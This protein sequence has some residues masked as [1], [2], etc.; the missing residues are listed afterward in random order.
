MVTISNLNNR[1]EIRLTWLDSIRFISQS[2]FV[3]NTWKNKMRRELK[4]D[5]FNLAL[6]LLNLY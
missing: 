1:L 5:S 6:N 2:T 3:E 4:R